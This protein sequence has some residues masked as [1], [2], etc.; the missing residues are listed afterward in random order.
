MEKDKSI[1]ERFIRQHGQEVGY[2][3]EGHSTISVAEF[4]KEL[5]PYLRVEVFNLL[6]RHKA[7][8]VI[9]KLDLS[10]V[11]PIVESVSP[12]RA[13]LVLRQLDKSLQ[14]KIINAVSKEVADYLNVTLNYAD[15]SVGA[16]TDAT[17]FTLPEHIL[18]GDALKRIK[19]EKQIKLPIVFALQQDEKLAGVIEIHK[20][21]TVS[22][23]DKLGSIV[24]RNV[25]RLFVQINISSMLEH[26]GWMQYN[27]LPVVNRSDVFLGAVRLADV[28]SSL[29]SDQERFSPQARATSN[30]LGELYKIG[31]ASFMRIAGDELGQREQ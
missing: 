18:V 3:L 7:A 1:A 10:I 14:K 29:K 15:D 24:N 11:V 19:K 28:R 20:L 5:S 2:I 8:D 16:F 21:L 27:A 31:L 13:D 25:P 23:G 22:S 30:A 26:E 6:D 12:L 4:I 17:V 9:E